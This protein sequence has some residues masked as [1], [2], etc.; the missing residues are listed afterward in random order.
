MNDAFEQRL[1]RTPII[2]IL[3]GLRPEEAASIGD[4][5]VRAGVD[6]LEVPLNSPE[7]FES[8]RRLASAFG[9]RASIGVGTVLT[10]DQVRGA[11]AA[12]A[13]FV[14]AP[15]LDPAVLAEASRL[16]MPTLPGVMS[17][18]EAFAAVAGGATWI[19]LFPASVMGVG[20]LR[21]LRA[22]LPASVR[23]AAVGGVGPDTAHAWLR[24]G[25]GAVGVGTD[26]FRPSD[27][28][29]NVFEKASRLME[30]TRRVSSP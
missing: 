26:L 23:V 20:G 5:L 11:H 14:V 9:D 21:A 22:V 28:P 8:I 24:A 25:A 6:T 16:E 2:A 15:N 4:A 29:E 13:R 3:R 7:P 27:T 1:A 18:T 12:G 30:A 17:P 19:K 10:G